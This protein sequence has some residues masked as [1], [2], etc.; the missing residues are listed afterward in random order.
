M[1][2]FP[3]SCESLCDLFCCSQDYMVEAGV[4]GCL[5]CTDLLFAEIASESMII[6]KIHMR[7]GLKDAVITS[8]D[9]VSEADYALMHSKSVLCPQEGHWCS[10]LIH[11]QFLFKQKTFFVCC[12]CCYKLLQMW[13]LGMTYLFPHSFRAQK[14]SIEV[15]SRLMPPPF[16]FW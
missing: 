14:F 15:V 1:D 8:L 5:P 6:N 9:C 4:F 7:G 12:G 2:T 10:L 11:S 3:R 13:W 16:V